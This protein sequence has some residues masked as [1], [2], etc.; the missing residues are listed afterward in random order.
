[1]PLYKFVGNRILTT[2]PER[3]RPALALSEWHCGY[4]AYRVAAL[5]RPPVRANSD[6]FDF[7][8]EIILQLHSA[9][10]RIVEVPIPTYYG[11]EICYV[12][13][14]RATPATS[15]R[16]VGAPPPR[17]AGLRRRRSSRRVDEPYALKPSPRQLAR[18]RRS[19]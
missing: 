9:G 14:H 13:G 10:K 15:S 3:R 4:R 11:D 8:T 16:D 7:D 6:G 5:R 18:P 19:S 1:M 12:N 17:Q 2:L